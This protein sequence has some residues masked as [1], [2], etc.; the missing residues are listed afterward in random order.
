MRPV[1]QS[2]VIAT[3]LALVSLTQ[4]CAPT[5]PANDDLSAR[6]RTG[7][8]LTRSG[9]LVEAR[10]LAETYLASTQGLPSSQ[11]RCAMLV[12]AAYSNALL[13]ENARGETQLRTFASAC[14]QF[15]LPFG[16]HVEAGR[17]RSLLEGEKPD[18]VYP[19]AATGARSTSSRVTAD[20]R[21][22]DR[23]FVKGLAT[24]CC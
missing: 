19:S 20:G 16:W 21:P 7:L 24:G 12:M 10:V 8:Q 11:E 9:Q 15:P 14:A 13:H 4:A 22:R 2:A 17:V 23:G 3:A 18:V 5:S 6:V 1:Y